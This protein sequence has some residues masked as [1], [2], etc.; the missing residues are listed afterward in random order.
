MKTRSK[1]TALVLVAALA[2]APIKIQAD[3]PPPPKNDWAVVI[4]AVIGVGLVVTGIYLLNKKC[5]PK[6]YWLMNSDEPPVFWIGTATDRECKIQDWH[7]IGGPYTSPNQAPPIHPDKTNRVH[8]LVGPVMHH[9]VEE[10]ADG[11]NWVTIHEEDST[12]EDFGYFVSPTNHAG[13]FRLRL[14]Q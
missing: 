2:I 9:A 13:F 6:Y 11:V 10:S 14:T 12:Q 7:K 4:C 8:E 1:L 3:E 5:Q